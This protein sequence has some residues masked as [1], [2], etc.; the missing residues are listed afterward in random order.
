MEVI[1]TAV[2]NKIVRND[3]EQSK[4]LNNIIDY[5]VYIM[6]TVEEFSYA[7]DSDQKKY[8]VKTIAKII[9]PFNYNETITED[10]IEAIIDNICKAS[11][12]N[13]QL[14]KQ[15]DNR[16]WYISLFCLR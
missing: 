4:S 14:N 6:E 5:V 13:I 9:N 2:Y 8:I 11:K 15:R 16:K 7:L 1:Q 12:N 3:N 10:M